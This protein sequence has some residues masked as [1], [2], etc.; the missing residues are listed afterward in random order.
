MLNAGIEIGM[1]DIKKVQAVHDGKADFVVFKIRNQ[2]GVMCVESFPTTDEDITMFQEDKD[3]Y[4]N[5]RTRVYPKLVAA[6]NNK[7]EPLFII[8]DFKYVFDSRKCSK[9]YF[10]GWSPEKSNVK[11]KMLFA[12]TYKQFADTLNIPI[13]ITAHTA[14]DISYDELY[15]KSKNV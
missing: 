15:S 14:N 7:T 3:K 9:L 10:I 4:Y 12:L 6:I 8:L 1:E 5:W 11:N 2:K 13:R